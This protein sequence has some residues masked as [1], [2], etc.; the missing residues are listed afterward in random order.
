MVAGLGRDWGLNRNRAAT[1]TGL[2]PRPGYNRR[3]CE[4]SA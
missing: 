2:P 3:S 4:V 1:A